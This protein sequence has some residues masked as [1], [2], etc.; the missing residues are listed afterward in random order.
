[1]DGSS[2]DNDGA[3]WYCQTE[4][5]RQANWKGVTRVNQCLKASENDPPAPIWQIWAGLRRAPALRGTLW[6]IDVAGRE[7]TRKYCGVRVAM[8]WG[9]NWAPNPMNGFVMNMGTALTVPDAV[10]SALA[11]GKVHRQLMLSVWGGGPVVVRGRES[12]PHG[13]GVQQS[14]GDSAI[15][16][17]RW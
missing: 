5:V 16:G 11:A 12:R 4:R 6:P 1:M 3:F 14:R 2:L 7:A 17:G 10:G 15:Q 8:P 13:E 9:H